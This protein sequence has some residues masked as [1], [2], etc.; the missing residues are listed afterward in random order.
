MRG[1]SRKR[2]INLVLRGD[3]G[4]FVSSNPCVRAG[5]RQT[6][7]KASMQQRDYFIRI[8]EEFMAAVARFLE[9]AEG[10]RND[11]ELRD[12]YRQ[13]VGDYEL[14]RNMTVEEAIGY[15]HEQ[16]AEGQ[17][18]QKLEMLAELLYAEGSYKQQPLRGMLLDKAFRLYDYVDG[19]SSDFSLIRKQRIAE[20]Q[21]M[22]ARGTQK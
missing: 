13:Y 21:G 4:I 19:H 18:V 1:E 11:D 5:H 15:A 12:L 9:K 16:W 14:L 2:G 20:I 17:R 3:C 22:I 10:K 6:Q 8:I 7:K